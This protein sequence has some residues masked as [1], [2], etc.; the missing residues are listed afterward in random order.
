MTDLNDQERSALLMDAKSVQSY[1]DSTHAAVR[2]AEY[3]IGALEARDSNDLHEELAV[4]ERLDRN[5]ET[6]SRVQNA[7]RHL[8]S[9]NADECS[10]DNSERPHEAKCGDA[11]VAKLPFYGVGTAV[12]GQGLHWSFTSRKGDYSSAYTSDLTFISRLVPM[13][14]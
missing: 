3:V 8:H 11:W 10:A 6:K 13:T 14:E 4:R 5:P 1:P 2:L 9:N 12:K 7:L